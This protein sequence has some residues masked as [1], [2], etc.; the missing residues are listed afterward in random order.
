[1]HVFCTFVQ[2][3][4]ITVG[5]AEA[6]SFY[7]SIWSVGLS[8]EFGIVNEGH[9]VDVLAWIAI[10]KGVFTV[11]LPKFSI[12][13]GK[14]SFWVNI[15]F[16]A[17]V[18]NWCE[19]NTLVVHGTGKEIIT[20]FIFISESALGGAVLVMKLHWSGVI[21]V[22]WVAC[23]LAPSLLHECWVNHCRGHLHWAVLENALHVDGVWICS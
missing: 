12:E 16:W 1:M 15:W 7:W 13:T 6:W 23:V 3:K 8:A 17:G 10:P 20:L 21:V 9:F 19:L 5:V 22:E 11:L 4:V 14:R 18:I 2:E